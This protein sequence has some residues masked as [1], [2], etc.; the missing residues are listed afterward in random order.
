M[1]AETEEDRLTFGFFDID[2]DLRRKY[3]L[4]LVLRIDGFDFLLI[5]WMPCYI[6]VRWS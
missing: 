1:E 2:K 6:A 5:R 4:I 3:R